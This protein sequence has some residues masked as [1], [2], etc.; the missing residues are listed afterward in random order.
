MP[1]RSLGS[2][3]AMVFTRVRPE[4]RWVYPWSL[5]SLGCAL[6][7]VGFIRGRCVNSGAPWGSL[8]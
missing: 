7:V 1:W 4:G 5:G 2:S 3:R 6:G 8:R